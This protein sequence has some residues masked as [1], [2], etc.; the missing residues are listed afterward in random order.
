MYCIKEKKLFCIFSLFSFYHTRAA[1]V[2]NGTTTYD[3]NYP[4]DYTDD[5]YDDSGDTKQASIEIKSTPSSI[6]PTSKTSSFIFNLF[7]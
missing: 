7:G 5:Y 6:I 1:P 2:T 4:D 3:D